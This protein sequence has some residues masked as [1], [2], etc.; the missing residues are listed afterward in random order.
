MRPV[1]VTVTGV[2]VSPPI[3]MDYLA[4]FFAVG[5]GCVVNGTV[6]YTVQHTFDDV[7]SP[8]FNPST[9]NWFSNT[10]ITGKTANT[11]GNY[12]FPVRAIRLNV[13]SGT[14][15]VTMTLIQSTSPSGS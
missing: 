4:S 10:G 6:N 5:V 13:A 3:P 7:F 12:A 11:D 14:G 8:T 9:A 15:S 1:T 2:G